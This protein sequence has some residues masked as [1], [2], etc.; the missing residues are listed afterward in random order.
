MRKVLHFTLPDDKLHAAFGALAHKLHG[1][2]EKKYRLN[3][4]NSLWGQQGFPI[5]EEFLSLTK[6][7]YAGGYRELDFRNGP[8]LARNTINRWVAEKTESMIPSLLGEDD[9]HKDTTL[10]LVNAIYFKG[11]WAKSFAKQ[12]TIDDKFHIEP[13]KNVPVRMMQGSCPARYV[14]ADGV[15]VLVLPYRDE[16]Q[17]MVVVL[18][19]EG[20][21]LA[22]IEQRLTTPLLGE[23]ITEST[24]AKVEVALPRYR[25]QWRSNVARDLFLLGMRAPFGLDADFS[26]IVERGLKVDYVIHEAVIDVSEEGT[27]AAAAT[28][29]GTRRPIIAVVPR[30]IIFRADRPFLYFLIGNARREILFAGRF[31]SP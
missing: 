5:R 6:H 1:A 27:E 22:A 13:G 7:F 16:T 12:N 24:V 11:S 19:A 21:T 30:Q 4:A 25:S 20:S 9:V 23:W 18:P 8:D 15:Q 31:G 2:K 3:I 29:G 26:G 14:A 10:V 17:S 28:A